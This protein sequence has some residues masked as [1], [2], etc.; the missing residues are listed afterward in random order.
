MARGYKGQKLGWCDCSYRPKLNNISYKVIIPVHLK[1]FF[2]PLSDKGV[3]GVGSTDGST[4]S[5]ISLGFQW[6]LCIPAK[7]TAR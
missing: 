1:G 3:L 7:H 6:Q 2:P 4:P 5:C